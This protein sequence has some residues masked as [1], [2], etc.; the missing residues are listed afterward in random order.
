MSR[1]LDSI[2]DEA[3]SV[4]EGKI[5]I[6]Y[7]SLMEMISEESKIVFDEAT[8]RA[9]RSYYYVRPDKLP[10]NLI[11]Q[12]IEWE[13][14]LKD[15]DVK[16]I[17]QYLNDKLFVS[18]GFDADEAI[19]KFYF[20]DDGVTRTDI[21]KANRSKSPTP[22]MQSAKE[23]GEYKK[24]VV[25]EKTK[26]SWLQTKPEELRAENEHLGMIKE[27]FIQAGI[28]K[29]NPATILIEGHS[30]SKVV[31]RVSF[32]NKLKSKTA[33]GDFGLF[34][35][36]AFDVDE[37][38]NV[39]YSNQKEAPLFT[40]SHKAI[41]F[42][43]YA[44]MVSTLKRL[45]SSEKKAA[46]EFLN[47]VEQA[48]K[49]SVFNMVP[50]SRGF[51]QKVDDP[52]IASEVVYL[53]YGKSADRADSLYVGEIDL[54]KTGEQA[55]KLTVVPVDQATVHVYP[56]IPNEPEYLPIFK[57]RYGSGGSKI[58]FSSEDI[59][60]LNSMVQEGKTTVSD[61]SK[62]RKSGGSGLVLQSEKDEITE[63]E[64]ILGAHLPVR[65]YISPMR[66]ADGAEEIE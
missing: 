64:I 29:E 62:P 14:Q 46:V 23:L 7:K 59:A 26:I 27:K 8:I 36:E 16:E 31:E 41:G 1:D 10:K 50:S 30:E 42:E 47:K 43:R 35:P 32:I 38:G 48:W 21:M 9:S 5:N 6:T 63:E 66:R 44:A 65:F 4:K 34:G 49:D 20:S 13:P 57:T 2:I 58:G 17:T 22:N 56:E 55:F 37:K 19:F 39:D 53:I 52:G 12:I 28:T 33:V 54:K 25:V 40:M 61:L 3:L 15:R 11:N 45:D 18:Q 60:M 51:Y 24:K